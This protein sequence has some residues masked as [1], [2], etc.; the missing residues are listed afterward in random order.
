MQVKHILVSCANV[1]ALSFNALLQ[2][3]V[4]MSGFLSYCC[5]SVSSNQSYQSSQTAGINKAIFAHLTAVHG[6]FSV[7]FDHFLRWLC[8]KNP[9][10]SAVSVK[11]R[12]AR[13]A[14]T[15]MSLKSPFLPIH[16]ICLT[17]ADFFLT[18]SA[19]QNALSVFHV[20]SCIALSFA[21]L[22]FRTKLTTFLRKSDKKGLNVFEIISMTTWFMLTLCGDIAWQ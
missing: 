6:M 17:W 19:C 16:M 7:F 21:F 13:L 9:C 14:P 15:S 8:I 3:S 4:V 2:S 10:R 20:I 11:L 5:L 12:P 18:T 1:S 22:S